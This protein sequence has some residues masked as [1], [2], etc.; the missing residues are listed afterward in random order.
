MPGNTPQEPAMP[1]ISCLETAEFL[2]PR[3]LLPDLCDLAT[4]AIA[5]GHGRLLQVLFQAVQGVQRVARRHIV[6]LQFI[7]CCAQLLVLIVFDDQ[8]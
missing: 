1:A 8:R 4:A 7:Q 3:K 6:R 2:R 5:R